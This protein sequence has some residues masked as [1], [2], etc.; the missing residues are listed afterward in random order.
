LI[1]DV[2]DAEAYTGLILPSGI[3]GVCDS[4]R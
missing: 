2:H 4:Q 1:A 3:I